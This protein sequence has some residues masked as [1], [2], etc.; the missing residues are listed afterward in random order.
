MSVSNGTCPLGGTWYACTDTTPY[1]FGC[2]T[3][4]PCGGTG[5]SSTN[6]L[7]AE[8]GPGYGFDGPDYPVDSSYYPNSQCVDAGAQW[9]TCAAAGKSGGFAFQGCCDKTAA[10]C[11]NNGS[12][13]QAN[14]HP[15][16]FS[17]VRSRTDSSVVCKNGQW[18]SC[19]T[20]NPPFQGCCLSDP[21]TGNGEAGGCIPSQSFPVVSILSAQGEGH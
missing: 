11:A 20:Q 21:C 8:L 12:C 17:D 9:F 15:A 6:L 13:P 7:A 16:A 19:V 4:N 5:C 18:Y 3:S 1:F 14:L 2:C 10:P